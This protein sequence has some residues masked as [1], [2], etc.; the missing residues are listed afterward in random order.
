VYLFGPVDSCPD[1]LSAINWKQE[2]KTGLRG[3][4]SVFD[5]QTAWTCDHAGQELIE[6]NE[7]VVDHATLLIGCWVPGSVGSCREVERAISQGKKVLAVV[8]EKTN[9]KSPYFIDERIRFY[10]NFDR[11]IAE[12]KELLV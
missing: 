3:I 9:C 1:P 11:V 7:F 6:I 12:A 5:P 8:P 2:V 4:A 10:D